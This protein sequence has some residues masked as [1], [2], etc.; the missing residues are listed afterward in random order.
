MT[1]IS[2]QLAVNSLVT[3]KVY[4]ILGREFKTL[5]NER[6][7]AGAHSVMF[8]ARTLASGVYFY[9]MQAGEFIQTRKIL[10]MK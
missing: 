6:Q 5:V 8:D 7:T 1:V 10:L 3:L 4:D 9:R 2:Y